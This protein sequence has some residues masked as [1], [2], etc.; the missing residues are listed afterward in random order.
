[1]KVLALLLPSLAVARV[2]LAAELTR[3]GA[4]APMRLYPWDEGAWTVGAG[5]LTAAGLRQQ[6]LIGTQMRYRYLTQQNLITANATQSQV[7]ILST[8]AGRTIMSAEAQV[9]G[10]YPPGTGLSLTAA[11][12][13]EAVPPIT[14]T[15]LAQLEEDLGSAALPEYAAIVPVHGVEIN[16]STTLRPFDGGCTRVTEFSARVLNG[17][18]VTAILEKYPN[19]MTT[20]MQET[21]FNSSQVQQEL[22]YIYDSLEAGNFSNHDL[23]FTPQEMEEIQTM[24]QESL[25]YLLSLSDDMN[26]LAG[27]PFLQELM[28]QFYGV[29]DNVC[30]YT[31]KFS[32]YISNGYSILMVLAALG[33]RDIP[34]PPYASVLLFELSETTPITTPSYSVTVTLNDQTLLIPTCPNVTCP[35]ETFMKYVTFRSFPD[36]ETQCKDS[37]NTDWGEMQPAEKGEL[38]DDMAGSDTPWTLWFAVSL[39]LV[40]IFTSVIL[41]WVKVKRSKTQLESRF[42]SVSGHDDFRLAV[43]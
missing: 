33:I 30:C 5:E 14:V 42:N 15:N 38:S 34:L 22:S 27:S 39:V 17:P 16:T 35:F 2:I 6:Y 11:Q 24:W 40:V 32:L 37:D 21:G 36:A 8:D 9:L 20:L 29:M 1:M 31:R 12:I 28:W 25:Q 41:I 3:N 4:T 26:R 18:T 23:P 7:Y 19:V 43:H 13:A 10:L